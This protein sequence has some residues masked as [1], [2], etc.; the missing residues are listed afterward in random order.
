VSQTDIA[1]ALG[2]TTQCVGQW[3]KRAAHNGFPAPVATSLSGRRFW[4]MGEVRAWREEYAPRMGN[5]RLVDL[6]RSGPR[7]NGRNAPFSA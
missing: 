4:D 3:V 5:P 6:N 7:R 1:R 2:V